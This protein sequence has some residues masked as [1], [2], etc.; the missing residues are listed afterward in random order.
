MICKGKRWKNLF[1]SYKTFLEGE[2]FDHRW[3]PG[4]FGAPVTP[5]EVAFSPIQPDAVVSE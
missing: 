5:K 1:F 2:L 4:L 3:T